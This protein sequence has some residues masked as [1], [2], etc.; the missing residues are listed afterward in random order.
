[1]LYSLQR[2]IIK[3]LRRTPILRNQM[4]FWEHGREKGSK[5]KKGCQGILLHC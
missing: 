1:M 3:V 2:L 5:Q 4:D